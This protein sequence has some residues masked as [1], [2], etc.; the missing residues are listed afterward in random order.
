M[1]S[2][3][4]ALSREELE[5]EL[6][7]RR[8]SAT[9]DF[10]ASQAGYQALM[11]AIDDGFTIIEFIDGPEGE[12][13]DYVHVEA[14]SGYTRHTGITEIVGK[15]LRE[16]EPTVPE[17][18]LSL[19][20]SVLETG[21]P[22]RFEQEFVAVG[23]VIEVSA[24]RIEPKSLRQVAVLFRDI[25][26]R[27]QGEAALRA[28]EALAREQVQRIEKAFDDRRAAEVERD[29]ALAELKAL[30]D[31]LEQRVAKRTAELM[32]A[33]EQLRHAQKMEAVG[34]LTGG[35]AHDFNNLLA[36]ISGSLEL[37]QIR[38]AQGRTT[39][40]DRYVTGA[41]G[42][43]KRAAALTQ[44]LLAFS[45]RQTLDPSPTDINRLI[46]GMQDLIT[47]SV[48]PSI[49]V[50]TALAGG[51]WNCFVDAG[52]L[53]NALLNLCVNARDAMPEGGKLTIE[54]ANRWFDDRAAAQRGLAAGQYLS[55]CV[56]DTGTGM[57]ADVVERAFDPFY[58]TKP[59][60]QGTGL[61]LSMVHGFAGQSGGTARI[62]S[63]L[64]KGTMV[65][66]YLPRHLGETEEPELAE[67]QG[68]ATSSTEHETVLVVDDEPLVQMVAVEI[69][70][71]LGYVVLEAGDGPAA[72]KLIASGR[73][74]D[75]LVTDVGLPSG[76]NGRQ[77]ADAAR[78]VLPDL[79]VLFVTGYAE[80]AVLN[81]G[82]LDHGMHVMTKPFLSDAFARKVRDL[83][84]GSSP[85][86]RSSQ[87]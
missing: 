39:E 84:G 61:G 73:H 31:T 85:D 43:A 6:E 74:I 14:N 64:G 17:Q 2:D 41:Q 59:T 78:Q 3:V 30:N 24:T 34:Q 62:Y 70:E 21:R 75:L 47:R 60:G 38:L 42:A 86:G 45:R 51:L 1:S 50:E 8:A 4:T 76:M 54:T 81:H 68:E 44:R 22:I 46:S 80:N 5:A 25:S 79:P 49:A 56:S 29:R 83:L 36:G 87:G 58:T 63:E 52:Q 33:E 11:E 55:L 77:L 19:Y 16:I 20:G 7:Q 53:E 57:T 28:S 13:S 65:C 26:E 37:M 40:L 66:I 12:L 69:L 35:L 48:G 82:H 9:A 15:R 72:M 67:P 27:K 18:W 10:A 23:R 71:D 32:R